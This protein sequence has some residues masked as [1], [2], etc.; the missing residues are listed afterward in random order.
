MVISL[1]VLTLLEGVAF[2]SS[3]YN[4]SLPEN[5]PAG[6]VV[7]TVWAS[8]GSPLYDVAYALRTHTDVFSVNS[9]GAVVTRV[10]LDRERQ[11]WFILDLEAVDTRSPPTTAVAV[12]RP[13]PPPQPQHRSGGLD[14]GFLSFRSPSRW[15]T[16]ASRRG[17]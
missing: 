10:E 9:S 16:L 14:S 12:V 17:F 15:R 2:R 7:G 6:A 4:F 3:S 5:Q 1:K 11:E 13:A 8:S